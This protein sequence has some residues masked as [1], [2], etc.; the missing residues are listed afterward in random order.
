[1][2]K[3]VNPKV[4]LYLSRVN[5]ERT[6]DKIA[7]QGQRLSIEIKNLMKTKYMNTRD[8]KISIVS[9]SMGGLI[10]RAAFEYLEYYK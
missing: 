3:F 7:D 8:I 2:I 10:A 9:H 4:D 5:E 6:D 1:M